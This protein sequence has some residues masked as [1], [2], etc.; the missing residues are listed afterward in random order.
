MEDRV[1]DVR[2]ADV[3]DVGGEGGW[4]GREEER[5]KEQGGEGGEEGEG[6]VACFCGGGMMVS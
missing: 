2:C 5:G 4:G 6:D 3:F 1:E